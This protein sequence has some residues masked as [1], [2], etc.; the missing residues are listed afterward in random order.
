MSNIVPFEFDGSQVRVI[1]EAGEPWWIVRD[2]CGILGLDDARKTMD[3]VDEDE[4]KIF[5][6]ID[7][8]GRRQDMWL[9][10][11][12]GL[13]S[14][15]LRSNKPEAKRFR[16]WVTSEVLPAI[17]KTGRYEAPRDDAIVCAE[18]MLAAARVIE[19]QREQLAVLAPKAE[20]FDQLMSANGCQ[21]LQVVGKLPGMPG[22]NNIFKS[23]EKLRIIYREWTKGDGHYWLPFEQH[24][25]AGRFV[26]KET[27]FQ[28]D[29]VDHFR[30]RVMVTPKGIEYIRM[31]LAEQLEA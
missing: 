7:S 4:R 22:P 18:G 17:R 6:V 15:I 5:P 14:L 21:P 20:S 19:R 24:I 26:V 31:R 2:I 25:K 1:E 11:E 12:S 10:N 13:Y 3:R 8:V 27:A 29:G 9:V 30:P 28:I 16:K 23:L